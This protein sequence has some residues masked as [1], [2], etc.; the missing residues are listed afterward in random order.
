MPWHTIVYYASVGWVTLLLSVFMYLVFLIVSR[1]GP[2]GL[3]FVGVAGLGGII[4]V[5][6]LAAIQMHLE[7]RIKRQKRR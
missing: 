1:Q 7:R 3:I 5:V 4:G 2:D 6:A